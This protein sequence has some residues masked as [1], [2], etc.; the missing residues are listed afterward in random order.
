MKLIHASDKECY[1]R[2]VLVYS[3]ISECDYCHEEKQILSVDTSDQEYCSF[4]CCLACFTKL[5]EAQEK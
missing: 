3:G 1:G 2:S 5:L 4:D